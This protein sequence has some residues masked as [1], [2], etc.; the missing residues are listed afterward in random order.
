MK[1]QA[2]QG[3]KS[4]KRKRHKKGVLYN[5]RIYFVRMELVSNTLEVCV[6]GVLGFF[7][8][9]FGVFFTNN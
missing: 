1:T 6:W 8:V 3:N 2:N 5:Y 7:G 4:R 9:L